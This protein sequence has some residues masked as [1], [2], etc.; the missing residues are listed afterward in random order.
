MFVWWQAGVTAQRTTSIGGYGPRRS[1]GRPW[2]SGGPSRPLIQPACHL[3]LR[4]LVSQ[5]RQLN[6]AALHR[7]P[8]PRIKRAAGGRIDRARHVAIDQWREPLRPG[9]RNRHRGEQRLGIGMARVGEQLVPLRDLDDAAEIHQ[10]EKSCLRCRSIR[11]FIT[12]AWIDTSSADTGSSHTIKLG[13]SDS[14]R[15][16]QMR[17]RSPPE[18]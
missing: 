2:I 18:K 13:L 3:M 12:W 1:P 7:I 17:R 10:Y 15:A 4:T 11:R 9:I 14:A 8:A 6:P 5:F 16:I